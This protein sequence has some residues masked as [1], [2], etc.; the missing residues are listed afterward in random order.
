MLL[1]LLPPFVAAEP[2]TGV[3]PGSSGEAWRERG[4]N[5][6]T[7]SVWTSLTWTIPLNKSLIPQVSTRHPRTGGDADVCDSAEAEC[8]D[9]PSPELSAR[10]CKGPHDAGAHAKIVLG[11]DAVIAAGNKLHG[12]GWN[13]RCEV[14]FRL[15]KAEGEEEEG[16]LS[17]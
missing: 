13:T 8:N 17:L 4:A 10:L 5:T 9:K 16:T 14:G 1:L 12:W 3:L 2:L 15:A 6:G 7:E 11:T